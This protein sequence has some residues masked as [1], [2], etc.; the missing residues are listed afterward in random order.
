MR[1]KQIRQI[2]WIVIT[3]IIIPCQ[4]FAESVTIHVDAGEMIGNVKP[5]MGVNAGP[6]K[7]GEDINPH[8]NEQYRDMGIRMVRTHDFYGP[9][10]MSVMYSDESADPSLFSSYNF[11]E[12]DKRMVA[13]HENGHEIYLRLGNSWNNSSE[14]PKNITNYVEAAKNV[15]RHYTQG[16]WDGFHF[17]I[18]YVEVW[19]EPDNRQFWTGTRIEFF[20]FFER[21]VKSL[22]AEFPHMKIGGPGFLPSSYLAQESNNTATSLLQYCSEQNVP[23]DFLSWHI[24]GDNPADYLG[25]GLFYR[26]ILDRFGY[27]DAESHISEW[28]VEEGPRRYNAEGAALMTGAWISLQNSFVDQSLFFRGQDSSIDYKE[29]YGL[30]FADGTYKK[31]AYAFKSWSWV[32]RYPNRITLNEE[33][34]AVDGIAAL[35]EDGQAIIIL[36]TH[37]MTDDSSDT[38][39]TYQL[40]IDGWIAP[41]GSFTLKRYAVSALHNLSLLEETTI[42]SVDSALAISNRFPINSIEV[43]MLDSSTE[44]STLHDWRMYR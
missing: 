31:M 12:S 25:A 42:E 40:T 30:L 14:T 41:E 15:I 8:V 33:S 9:V 11:V 22:K 17:P 44:T 20:Q 39:D 37:Y 3:V 4:S 19:N 32:S 28:N 2:G 6:Y 5:L 13:I 34:D 21:M 36:L 35:D 10:D 26:E 23:L 29:W 7:L 18:R 24:Y 38:I 43:L 16:L 27:T 1:E